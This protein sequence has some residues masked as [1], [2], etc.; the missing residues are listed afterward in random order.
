MHAACQGFSL[1]K[2]NDDQVV[3][4]LASECPQYWQFQ[5]RVV[6]SF[7]VTPGEEWSYCSS[8]FLQTLPNAVILQITRI[9]NRCIWE[10]YKFERKRLYIKN[11]GT[12]NELELFHG[13]IHIQ[14]G[15]GGVG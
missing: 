6:E 1:E 5:S 2:M 4:I 3:P 13:S 7:Q 11:K 14:G 8:K 10:R 12:I 15:G 9:Q